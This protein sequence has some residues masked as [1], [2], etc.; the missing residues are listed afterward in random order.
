MCNIKLR[1]KVEKKQ[2]MTKKPSRVDATQIGTTKAEFQLELR[3]RFETLQKLDDIDTMSETITYMVL[4]S[5]SRELK[6]STSH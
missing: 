5:A 1:L 2:C 3:N 4:Q 6:Q